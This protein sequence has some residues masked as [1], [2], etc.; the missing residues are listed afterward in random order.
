MFKRFGKFG[1]NKIEGLKSDVDQP[2]SK[3][4]SQLMYD[5]EFVIS[6]VNLSLKTSSLLFHHAT[7]EDDE[8]EESDD[9][10]PS[11]KDSTKSAAGQDGAKT[12]SSNKL[13]RQ[14]TMKRHH[15][16]EFIFE[17]VSGTLC[18]GET[19]AILGNAL[20]HLYI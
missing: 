12:K 7:V 11:S 6:W 9:L 3:V 19:T 5:R 2:K 14:N 13:T 10:E 4:I 15:R 1:T 16:R 20:A 17:H 18:S 8:F